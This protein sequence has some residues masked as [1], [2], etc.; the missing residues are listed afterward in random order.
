MT[1]KAPHGSP[2]VED[3]PMRRVCPFAPPP[4]YA[5]LRARTPIARIT[6]PNGHTAWL[7]T[8]HADVRAAL[9]HPRVSSDPTHPGFPEGQM[10]EGD[11]EERRAP[12]LIERDPPQHG[13]HRRMLIPEFTVRRVDALR[14]H[15]QQTADRLLDDMLHEGPPADLVSAFAL[16]LSSLTICHLLGVPYADHAFF[17]AQARAAL[18]SPPAEAEAAFAAVSAYLDGLVTEKERQPTD[19]MISRLIVEHLRTGALTHAELVGAATLLLMAG[20]ETTANMISLGVVTLL[21]HPD[22]LA[23]LRADWTLTAGTVEEMLRYHSIGDAGAVRVAVDDIEIGGQH[24]RAGDGIIPLVASANRDPLAFERPEDL[25]IHRRGRHHLGFGHGI[26]QCL[27][28]NLARA[29][30]A[31]AYRTLFERL[32]TLRLDAPW[33]RSPSSTR[34]RSSAS[35]PSPSPG[36]LPRPAR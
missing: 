24:I 13:R 17:E 36:E 21:A 5:E 7:L 32:P 33:T 15:L 18:S 19:D 6:L 10:A 22:Q 23:Q 9:G 29:E 16:P 20:H 12:L 11:A 28:Q 3:F 27:G 8:R 30:I 2:L 31:I 25:D 1:T 35:T 34:P 26:H 14:P 4:R